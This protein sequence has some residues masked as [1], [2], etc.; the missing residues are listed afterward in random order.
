MI[1]LSCSI[2]Y[3][4]A[5]KFTKFISF[6]PLQESVFHI[7]LLL[8]ASSLWFLICW[9]LNRRIAQKRKLF[10]FTPEKLSCV[11][12]NL[13]KFLQ[14]MTVS[15]PIYSIFRPEEAWREACWS[16][17]FPPPWQKASYWKRLFPPILMGI[18]KILVLLYKIKLHELQSLGTILLGFPCLFDARG[19]TSRSTHS[20]PPVLGSSC[21]VA[22]SAR[23]PQCRGRARAHFPGEG[24]AVEVLSPSNVGNPVL[25]LHPEDESLVTCLV[26]WQ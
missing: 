18:L 13:L 21:P 16:W 1:L 4:W 3:D 20:I 22:G 7:Q 11:K 23:S 14:I 10:F 6:L 2:L 9:K 24:C 12:T 26:G 15:R 19:V 17:C 8:K 5:S 25:F